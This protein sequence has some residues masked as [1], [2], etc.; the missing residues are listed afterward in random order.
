MFLSTKDV[1]LKLGLKVETIRALCRKKKLT[2]Y[3]IGREWKFN[4]N[5][6]DEYINKRKNTRPQG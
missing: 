2:A 1:S 4:S 3:R 6:I 5:D